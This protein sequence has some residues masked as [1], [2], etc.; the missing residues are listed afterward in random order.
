[1][2][3][4]AQILAEL[5]LLRERMDALVGELRAGKRRASKRRKSVVQRA[6][7]RV[8]S[9]AVTDLDMQLARNALRRASHR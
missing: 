5:Q 1:M 7:G 6:L 9:V 2:N 8:E 4:S 3:E